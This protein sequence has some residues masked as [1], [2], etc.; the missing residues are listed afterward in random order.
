VT[1]LVGGNNFASGAIAG[2]SG[3]LVSCPLHVIKI[4]AQTSLTTST[5]VAAAREIYLTGGARGFY[6]GLPQ[7]AVRD[8]GFAGAYLGTYGSLR[9]R[10]P[11]SLPMRPAVAAVAASTV[12]WIALQPLDTVK[13]MSQAGVSPGDILQRLKEGTGHADEGSRRTVRSVVRRAWRGLGAA[14]MR[15]GPVNATGMMV[16]EAAK[17]RVVDWEVAHGVE[18]YKLGSHKEHSGGNSK[19]GSRA[20]AP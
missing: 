11:E 6:R 13:T 1:P 14:L 20:A 5:S 12:T 19:G 8:C 7:H 17:K 16:Y 9:D 2:I 10:L 3:T 15:A 4:R 18:P